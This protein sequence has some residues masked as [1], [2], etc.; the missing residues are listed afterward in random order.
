MNK[1]RQVTADHL[2]A[3][4]VYGT[5]VARLGSL[6]LFLGLELNTGNKIKKV[7]KIKRNQST[8]S[9]LWSVSAIRKEASKPQHACKSG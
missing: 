8:R 5:S 4:T 6:M 2:L 7:N 3:V 9:T 1:N